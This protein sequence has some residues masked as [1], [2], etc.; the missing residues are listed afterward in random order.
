M[1][2]KIEFDLR[3]RCQTCRKIS[4]LTPSHLI[5]ENH[6]GKGWAYDY[7]DPKNYFTQCLECHMAYEKLGTKCKPAFPNL[8]T[9]Q[10][11]LRAHGLWELAARVD[12][13]ITPKD[14]S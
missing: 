3:E 1:K 5:K 9:R 2:K 4:G 7:A 10:D 12:R 8:D 13:L 14:L 11:Y 6:V